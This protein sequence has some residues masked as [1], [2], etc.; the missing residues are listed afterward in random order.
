MK[1]NVNTVT[2]WE[3]QSDQK[4]YCDASDDVNGTVHA[5][6]YLLTNV[7]SKLVEVV[8]LLHYMNSESGLTN[9]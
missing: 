5:G 4:R 8:Y 3:S 6:V 9:P 1:S 7:L 2:N